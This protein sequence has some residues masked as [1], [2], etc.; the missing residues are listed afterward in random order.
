[1]ENVSV[2]N[3]KPMQYRSFETKIWMKIKFFPNALLIKCIGINFQ[4]WK[5]WS[6]NFLTREHCKLEILLGMSTFFKPP[7]WKSL[8]IVSCLIFTLPEFH[9]NS[10][11]IRCIMLVISLGIGKTSAENAFSKHWS[12]HSQSSFKI[13]YSFFKILF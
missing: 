6:Y 8:Q 1:M 9:G 7:S 10:L 11:C 4:S 12:S 13:H 5:F 3:R 2:K